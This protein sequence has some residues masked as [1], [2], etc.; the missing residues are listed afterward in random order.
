MLESRGEEKEKCLKKK[1][2]AKQAEKGRAKR[3]VPCLIAP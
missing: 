2:V 3:I 1:M